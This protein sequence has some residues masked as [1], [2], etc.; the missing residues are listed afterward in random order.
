MMKEMTVRIYAVL[1]EASLLVERAPTGA[2]NFFTPFE[3]VYLL[4]K[5]CL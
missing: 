2:A 1:V 5:S 3:L 4:E